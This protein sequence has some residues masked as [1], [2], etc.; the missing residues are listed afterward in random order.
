MHRKDD[1][2]AYPDELHTAEVGITANRLYKQQQEFLKN[3]QQ[4]CGAYMP[5]EPR[6]PSAILA[7]VGAKLL[8]EYRGTYICRLQKH[9]ESLD[10]YFVKRIVEAAALRISW[11]HTRAQW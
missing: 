4:C 11:T 8:N 1:D 9:Q 10:R 5:A 7:V 2:D 3:I 6:V